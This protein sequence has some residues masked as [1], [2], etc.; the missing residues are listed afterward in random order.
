MRALT[1]NLFGHDGGWPARREV[2][3]VAD[4]RLALEEPVGGVL[5]SDHY[6]VVADLQVRDQG[7]R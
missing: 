7:P 2:Q 1:L 3:R 5:A 4:C 6:G